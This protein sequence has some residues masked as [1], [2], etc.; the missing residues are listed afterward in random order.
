MSNQNG[1]EAAFLRAYRTYIQALDWL[2]PPQCAGCGKPGSHWCSESQINLRRL[3]EPHCPSCGLPQLQ[4]ELCDS[5]LKRD[6]SYNQARSFAYYDGH[7]RRA[8]L[9]AKYRRDQAL[10]LIFAQ[11]LKQLLSEQK[12]EV[13]AVVPIPLSTE[14]L[15]Q[16]G[17][18]QV[19]L[20]ARPLALMKQF[21][22]HPKALLRIKET[23]SQVGLS[24]EARWHNLENAFEVKPDLVMA[25]NI[26]LLDDVMTTGATLTAASDALA[27]AGAQTVYCLTIARTVPQER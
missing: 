9:N 1:G 4:S 10:G 11:F 25:K 12:W 15:R 8:L 20:F 7:L 3:V 17:Y 21:E 5:C 22:F 2:F 27:A 23:V 14:R 26:L 18:N 6:P 24:L 19:D 16:R 13:D